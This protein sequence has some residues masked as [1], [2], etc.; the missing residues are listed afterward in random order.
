[1]GGVDEQVGG[2]LVGFLFPVVVV[3]YPILRLF[4]CR[5]FDLRLFCLNKDLLFAMFEDVTGL[6]EER[7]PKMLIGTGVG[8]AVGSDVGVVVGSK[9]T[10]V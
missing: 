10:A 9:A 6:V 2:K 3:L 7:G 8:V 4:D 5:I 1:V